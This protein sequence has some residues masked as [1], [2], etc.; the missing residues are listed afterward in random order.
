MLS[1]AALNRRS[2]LLLYVIQQVL[3]QWRCILVVV[4]LGLNEWLK[5]G[6]LFHLQHSTP[7]LTVC[8]YRAA[9]GCL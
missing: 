5:L 4:S 8:L 3:Q 7:V 9:R 6:D 1:L 2:L